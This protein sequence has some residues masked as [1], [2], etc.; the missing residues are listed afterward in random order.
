MQLT[1]LDT[2]AVQQIFVKCFNCSCM[3]GPFKELTKEQ[4]ARVDKGRTELTYAKGET[5]CKQGAF[6][7]NIIFIKEG[8]AKFY[9]DT[10][11][12]PTVISVEKNGYFIGL[13]SLFENNVYQFSV[14]ALEDEEVC[15]IDIKI[16]EELLTENAAFAAAT[17]KYLNF[18]MIK[19]YDRLQSV[20]QKQIHGRFAE[21]LLYLKNNIYE[22]NPFELSISKRDMADIISTSHESISRMCT[23][24]KNEGIIEEKGRIIRVLN[25]EKL[26]QISKFG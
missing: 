5:V 20:T 8:L 9:L 14:E 25:E 22:Q 16:F 11:P 7:S 6:I 4:M 15:L 21:F 17:I 24:L 23:Q 26:E 1:K 18:D 19:L 10:K 2:M 12:N 3:S 13:Q